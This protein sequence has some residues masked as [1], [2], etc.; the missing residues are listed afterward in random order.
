MGVIFQF[1]KVWIYQVGYQLQIGTLHPMMEIRWRLY[2][3]TLY[4]IDGAFPQIQQTWPW[5]K[6]VYNL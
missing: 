4:T 5:H 1:A 3:L 6:N 2:G